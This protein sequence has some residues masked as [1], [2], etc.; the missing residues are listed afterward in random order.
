M[1]NP[2]LTLGIPATSDAQSVRAAYRRLVKACHPDAVQGEA[3]KVRAQEQMIALNLAYEEALKLACRPT[4]RVT[5]T[6]LGE[7]LRLAERLL[8]QGMHGSAQRAL[9]RCDERSARW[10]YL[11]GQA[12]HGQTQFAQAHTSFRQAIRLEPANNEYRTAALRAYQAEKSSH[13]L[14]QRV[15]RW[16]CGKPANDRRRP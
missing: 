16:M 10:H 11:H 6:T 5:R 2:F 1:Q 4:V 13:K 8:A 12:L 9:E 14:P 7:A 3:Q 15:F